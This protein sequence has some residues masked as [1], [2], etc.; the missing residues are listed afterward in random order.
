MD[1]AYSQKMIRLS[2]CLVT[3]Q[4]QQLPSKIYIKSPGRGYTA[5]IFKK[6]VLG[7]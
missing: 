5:M 7:H 4:E 3:S 6:L 1:S 2:S